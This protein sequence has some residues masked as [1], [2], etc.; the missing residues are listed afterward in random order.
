LLLVIA[1]AGYSQNDTLLRGEPDS[2]QNKTA[3]G[4]NDETKDTALPFTETRISTSRYFALLGGNFK[5]ILVKPFQMEKMDWKYL[6]IAAAIGGVLSFGDETV[7][8]F[9]LDLRHENEPL[10]HT[11]SI[12]TSF[13]D[14]YGLYTLG[15]L[16]AY[17]YVFKK[18]KMRTTVLLASQAYITSGV[19]ASALKFLT[20]RT[21]PSFYK[22]PAQAE[23]SFFGPFVT[24]NSYNGNRT[25][26]SF[27]S[28][29]T[30]SAFAI[31]TVFAKQYR[32]RPW[33]PAVAYS[34]ATLVGL[35]RITENKHWVTDV[36]AGAALGY[37]TG[38][39]AVKNYRKHSGTQV[40]QKEK[41][42]SFYLQYHYGIV[43]PGVV[44]KI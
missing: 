38:L 13:G 42:A 32:D 8:R 16:G 1:T 10:C 30:T 27:P 35:S 11:S 19:L 37:I 22:P 17:G 6:S 24:K 12:V 39:Q 41:K 9:A 2:L 44:Y 7:Q 20:V 26:T 25:N 14:N 15:A 21:R 43:M 33:I 23:P 5:Q 4:H 31:A 29:H 34:T 40:P 3:I 36:F 18:E 28:G